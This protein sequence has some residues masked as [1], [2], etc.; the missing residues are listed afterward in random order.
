MGAVALVSVH[1]VRRD[2]GNLQSGGAAFWGRTVSEHCANV[3]HISGDPTDARTR[4]VHV[5]ILCRGFTSKAISTSLSALIVQGFYSYRIYALSERKWY[6]PVIIMTLGA[7]SLGAFPFPTVTQWR[8]A[9]SSQLLQVLHASC[10]YKA[11]AL[12]YFSLFREFTY[13]SEYALLPNFVL[14]LTSA[15]RTVVLWLTL[16]A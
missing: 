12:K 14:E 15:T 16:A 1:N 13:A 9:K 6:F 8:R 2:R 3:S 7:S 4:I 11:T 10:L 5:W